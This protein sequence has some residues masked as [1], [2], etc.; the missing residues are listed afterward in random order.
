MTTKHLNK[1]PRGFTLI[2]VLI[3]LAILASSLTILLGTM[4]A[5]GQQAAFS[6]DLTVASAL[7]RSKMVDVEYEIMEEGFQSDDQML[8][9]DFADEGHPEITWEADIQ[10]VEIPE[11]A[12]EQFLAQINS[13]LFGNQSQGAL[14]GNAAFSSMLPMLIAQLPEMINNIGKKIRRV[15][16]KIEFPRGNGV[17]PVTVIQYIVDPALN[18]FNVFNDAPG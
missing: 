12:K 15:K 4:A 6:N 5:S 9:G 7:A 10:V 14:Q 2:E 1:S 8:S 16:L 17:F 13:Q 11:S 18:E 3:A